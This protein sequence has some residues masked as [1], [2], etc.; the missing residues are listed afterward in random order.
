MANEQDFV[1]LGMSCVDVCKALDRGL[2]GRRSEELSGS[3]LEAIEQL[4]T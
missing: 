4:T 2:E 3:L 1:E